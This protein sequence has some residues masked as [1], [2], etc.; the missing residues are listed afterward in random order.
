MHRLSRKSSP[1]FLDV[2]V[3]ERCIILEVASGNSTQ[4]WA[5]PDGEGDCT[6]KPGL[7]S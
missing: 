4:V 3:A 7:P 5:G 2:H 1:I 6:S